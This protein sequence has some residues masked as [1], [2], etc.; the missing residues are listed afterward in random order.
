M[1]LPIDIYQVSY[2]IR[3]ASEAVIK[4]YFRKLSTCD[5]CQKSDDVGDIVTIADEKAEQVLV[6]G[7]APLIPNAGFLGEEMFADDP[8]IANGFMEK[9]WVWVIDPIDGSRN[10]AEGSVVF[11]VVVALLNYGRP[12]GGWIYDVMNDRM[13]ITVK[14]KGV[15]LDNIPLAPFNVD[16]PAEEMHG[17]ARANYFP[18]K[19][20]PII[21]N[22]FKKFHSIS[23]HCCA[24]HDYLGLLCGKGDFSLYAMLKPWDHVAGCL[25]VEELGGKARR[26]QG[27]KPYKADC[28]LEPE[29]RGLL[30]STTPNNW[31]TA[32]DTLFKDVIF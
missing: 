9:Q 25:M 15:T 28:F 6:Q 10:Y 19:I 22:N 5:I 23:K 30:I 24:S 7:L 27:F 21:H 20:H 26:L 4:P 18:T 31:Q 32:H 14:D 29:A 1:M 12:V 16:I 3:R 17:Y 8:S 2:I 13:A 11:S